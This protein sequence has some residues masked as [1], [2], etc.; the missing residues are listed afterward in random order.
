[1]GG[2]PMPPK[3]ST[4]ETP[5]VRERET[6]AGRPCHGNHSR[7]SCFSGGVDWVGCVVDEGEE[8]GG[9]GEF[10]AAD[11]LLCGGVAGA[12]AGGGGSISK[13]IWGGGAVQ[14]WGVAGGVGDAGAGGEWGFVFAGG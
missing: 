9:E 13:R 7:V 4:G 3:K 5:V 8:R 6:R 10:A 12:D 11:G 1:M 14:F 2:A